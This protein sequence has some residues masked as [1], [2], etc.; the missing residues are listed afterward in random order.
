MSNPLN[1][2]TDPEIK[3]MRIESLTVFPRTINDNETGGQVHFV[4]PNKGYLSSDSRI[5]LPT[6]CA[7]PAYQYPPNVGVFSLIGTA[8]LSTES[9]GVIAQI[10][11][12]GELYANMNLLTPPEKKRNIDSVLHGINYVFETASSSKCDGVPANVE[13]MPGMFRLQC[14]EYKQEAGGKSK[15]RKNA[16]P[17]RLDG[18]NTLKLTTEAGT[19]PQYSISLSD[20]FPGLFADAW[21]LPLQLIDEEILLDITFSNN[22][23]FG[24]NDR[25]IFCP[26]LATVDPT[27]ITSVGVYS[28]GQ[29]PANTTQKD[30][31]LSNPTGGSGSGLRLLCDLTN[32]AVS[33]IRVL[34][35]GSGYAE[36]DTFTFSPDGWQ[37]DMVVHPAHKFASATSDANFWP[38]AGGADFTQDDEYFV[39]NPYGE[40]FKITASNVNGGALVECT[41][42]AATN[43]Q[44]SLPREAG[45]AYVVYKADGT[46]DSNARLMI[47]SKE[48]VL[49][50]TKTGAVAEGD[51]LSTDGNAKQ[52]FILT[53]DGGEV[54]EVMMLKG[55]P[56][57]NDEFKID[58]G[59]YITIDSITSTS[60]NLAV[61]FGYD[62]VFSYDSVSGGKIN[63]DTNN[64]MITTD[65]VYYMDGKPEADL[66]AMNSKT[67]IQKLYTQYRNVKT[68]LTDKDSVATYADKKVI[69]YNRLIGFSNSVLRNLMWNV[70]PS[71]TQDKV[72]LP[73]YGKSKMNPLLLK[74]CS[75]ASAVQGGE[76]FNVNINSVPYYS[77]ELQTDMRFFR[78]LNKC[79]GNMFLNKGTYQLWNQCRQLDAGNATMSDAAPSAQPGF[80]D[81]DDNTEPTQQYQLSDVKSAVVMDSWNGISQ[82]H[83]RGMNKINGCS[84]ELI[85][86]ANVPRNGA[87]IGSQNIDINYSFAHTLDVGGSG[88]LNL[89]GKTERTLVLKNGKF[90]VTSA[91]F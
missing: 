15:G 48:V 64:V 45:T 19:T 70:Y 51:V 89:Y 73:Y 26:S 28:A 43:N 36:D 23:D 11:N 53:M 12:A 21:S 25:A 17:N 71:G 65:I 16:R 49:T 35:T 85:E 38:T 67:G 91:S 57:V 68:S 63:I 13:C 8:T 72:A 18:R 74:Y 2:V 61:Q 75:R 59:N 83:L 14:D 86:G 58:A 55:T 77:S 5:V 47:G 66:K 39:E 22:S 32:A 52:L 9:S 84:F 30:V 82:H 40:N 24:N 1:L 3:Q 20:L 60:N 33:N 34:D 46:T 80:S 37:S 4:L 6:K 7:D 90:S 69:S 27:A 88:T 76:T 10:D 87:E 31:I 41:I 44:L 56:A 54:T 79:E 42:D 29:G 62:P 50:S 81:I 78:E